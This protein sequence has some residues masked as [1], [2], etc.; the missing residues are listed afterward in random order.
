MR[1]IDITRGI[2]ENHVRDFTNALES[3]VIIVGAG[4]SGLV[5]GGYL[6][7][8]GVNVTILEK[9]LAPGGGI[10]GGGMGYKY[11]IIQEEAKSVLD[12]FDIPSRPWQDNM[13]AVDAITFASGLIFGASKMGANIFNLVDVEDLLVRDGR[14][15]GVVINNTFARMNHFPVDPLTLEAKAVVDATGH[16]HDIVHTL[17]RKNDVRLNTPSGKPEGERSLFAEPAEDAVVHNTTEVYPGL[18]VCGMSTAAVYGG[19][20]MGPIF[21]GMLLSGSKLRDLLLEVCGK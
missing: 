2:I 4:P 8:K 14:V 18:F 20:R 10:W 7:A 6:A 5:A 1:E 21:G 13:L 16:D 15:A 17:S 3:D 11:V 9:K 19:Y 12:D